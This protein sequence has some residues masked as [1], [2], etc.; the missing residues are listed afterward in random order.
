MDI[1]TD[2]SRVERLE[3]VDTGRRRRFSDAEKIRI[4]EES[5]SAPRMASATA[6]KHSIAVPMLFAWRKAYREGR[7]GNEAAAFYPVRVD[8]V[9]AHAGDGGVPPEP[10][11]NGSV[12]PVEIVL[13]NGRRM[14]VRSDI[15][16]VALGRLLD[17][18]ER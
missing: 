15:A 7:L 16:P 12:S 10:P 8:E 2:R 14:L 9:G 4:V 17:V 3:I 11:E 6:R 18:V 1:F 5:L 13:R